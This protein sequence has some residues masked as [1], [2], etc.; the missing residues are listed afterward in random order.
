MWID[1]SLLLVSPINF[2][3]LKKGVEKT[4]ANQMK[5]KKIQMEWAC[6]SNRNSLPNCFS[7][8]SVK[9]LER[10][11]TL[12]LFSRGKHDEAAAGGDL[13]KQCFYSYGTK[14]WRADQ[15]RA[16]PV[17]YENIGNK[18]NKKVIVA[19]QFMVLKKP[20]LVRVS[21]K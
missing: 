5:K 17:C 7:F 20:D 10:S 11:K 9:Y 1:G 6:D 4:C 13:H 16:T 12:K 3:S 15:R 8:S 19:L 2:L 14:H 18:W 21:Y